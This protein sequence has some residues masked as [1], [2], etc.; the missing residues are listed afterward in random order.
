MAMYLP[1]MLARLEDHARATGLDLK[2]GWKVNGRATPGLI[3]IAEETAARIDAPEARHLTVVHGD[4]CFSN[5]LY[6]FRSQSV[7][8]IDPRG[9]ETEYTFEYGTT[10]C[11]LPGAECTKIE[12]AVPEGFGDVAITAVLEGLTPGTT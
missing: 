4:S 6:D 7:R 3:Q 12:G 2:R 1:K 11:A 8:M 10:D 5:I 9:Q